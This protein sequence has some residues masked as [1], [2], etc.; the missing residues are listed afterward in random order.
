MS[1]IGV[2]ICWCGSNISETVDI[3]KTKAALEDLPALNYIEDYQY[4][5]SEIGQQKIADAI[6]NKDLNGVVVASCSPRMH[7]D[8]FRNAAQDAGL[9]PYLLEIANIREH[10]SWVH[11]DREKATEKAAALI[12]AAINKVKHSLLKHLFSG[13]CMS[14]GPLLLELSENPGFISID[15]FRGHLVKDPFTLGFAFPERDDSLFIGFTGFLI[16]FEPDFFPVVQ[17]IKIFRGMKRD[18]RIGRGS[19]GLRASFT[20]NQFPFID[21]YFLMVQNMLKG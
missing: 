12:R 2:F 4:L 1:K 16:Y 21:A 5:C 17:D 7:E 8:T 15:P 3:E 9:N 14:G 11:S 20:H 10:C 6:K 13:H 19:L 18:L